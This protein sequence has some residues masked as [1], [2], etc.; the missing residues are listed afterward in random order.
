MVQRR[1][2]LPAP[3]GPKIRVVSNVANVQIDP[4]GCR[5]GC[6]GMQERRRAWRVERAGVFLAARP[7]TGK[8][9]QV[10]QIAGVDQRPADIREGVPWQRTKPRFHGVHRFDPRGE[11][12]ALDFP[13]DQPG[14]FGQ[15]RAI[16]VHQH[17]DRR[18]V[19]EGHQCRAGVGNGGIR[20]VRHEQGVLVDGTALRPEHLCPEAASLLLPL[21]A[22]L[23]QF[24]QGLMPVEVDRPRGPPIADG[25]VIERIENPGETFGGE[26]FDRDAADEQV[27]EARCIAGPQLSAPQYRVEVGAGRGNVQR[28]A[29][30]SQGEMEVVHQFVAEVIPAMQV[31]D[32]EAV[33]PAKLNSVADR[34]LNIRQRLLRTAAG[35]GRQGCCLRTGRRRR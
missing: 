34:V 30:T 1:V 25:Q 14:A 26:A 3:V 32:G 13:D 6:R 20:L 16:L 21:A 5:A 24:A 15:C 31:G 29:F 23:P 33:H 17:D 9:Q 27:T 2:D 22:K 8:R 19:A 7:D 35:C 10:G 11:P 18:V 12:F 28:H 4:K